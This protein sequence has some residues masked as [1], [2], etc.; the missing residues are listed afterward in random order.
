MFGRTRWS[1][2]VGGAAVTARG[3]TAPQIAGRRG[4]FGRSAPEHRGQ[5][6]GAGRERVTVANVVGASDLAEA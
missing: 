6:L 3:G 4:M 5:V 2:V 1:L